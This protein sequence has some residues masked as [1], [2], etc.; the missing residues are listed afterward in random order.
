MNRGF[1]YAT[2]ILSSRIQGVCANISFYTGLIALFI[3]LVVSLILVIKPKK[4][5]AEIVLIYKNHLICAMGLL[6]ISVIAFSYAYSNHASLTGNPNLII[7]NI[8]LWVGCVVTTIILTRRVSRFT[9]QNSSP[10]LFEGFPH[11]GR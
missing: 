10:E 6:I 9:E 8:I 2:E 1:E 11:V 3:L 5:N 4:I 7:A